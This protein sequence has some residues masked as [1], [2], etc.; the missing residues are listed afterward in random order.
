[1]AAIG[2][3][4][5][6]IPASTAFQR[7]TGVL[8]YPIHLIKRIILVL[9]TVFTFLFGWFTAKKIESGPDTLD[10]LPANTALAHSRPGIEGHEEEAAIRNIDAIDRVRMT[11]PQ[12]DT[13]PS[14]STIELDISA[15]PE[16]SCASLEETKA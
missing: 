15:S 13:S 8:L 16:L 5:N 3:T 10:T 1:M 9:T 6:H 2:A 7:V 11:P 12:E 4:T 14:S